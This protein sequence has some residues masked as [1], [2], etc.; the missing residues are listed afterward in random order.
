MHVHI[1]YIQARRDV[2][3]QI[4]FCDFSGALLHSQ[5]TCSKVTTCNLKDREPDVQNQQSR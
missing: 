5:T 2:H 4:G 3:F 1:P